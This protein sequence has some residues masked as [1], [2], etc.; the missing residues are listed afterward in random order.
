[1]G[2]TSR[3]T[4]KKTEQ[5][6][7]GSH[8]VQARAGN[9]S[10]LL[11]NGWQKEKLRGSANFKPAIETRSG[12]QAKTGKYAPSNDI[13]A[14]K[15]RWLE[16]DA[17]PEKNFKAYKS[18]AARDEWDEDKPKKDADKSRSSQ[19]YEASIDSQK[20]LFFDAEAQQR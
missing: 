8:D 13:K 3:R 6:H 12:S 11:S 14:A 9:N 7:S 5:V 1:V 2:K 17:R 19:H 4:D 16:S 20:P 15:E 10:S 18:Q